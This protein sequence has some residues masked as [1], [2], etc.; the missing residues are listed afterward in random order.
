M[1]SI[2]SLELIEAIK[3]F[4]FVSVTHTN[5]KPT[6][7]FRVKDKNDF[8]LVTFSDNDQMRFVTPEFLA[9]WNRV[10]AASGVPVVTLTDFT[11]YCTIE[12]DGF[13][14]NPFDPNIK[15]DLV[16][17]LASAMDFQEAANYLIR[18][19]P[20]LD[21]SIEGA[22]RLFKLIDYTEPGGDLKIIT[23]NP[24]EAEYLHCNRDENHDAV[25]R[26]LG[27]AEIQ[28]ATR[29]GCNLPLTFQGSMYDDREFLNVV[30]AK[31]SVPVKGE[32]M[33]R[34]ATHVDI[35]NAIDHFIEEY[36]SCMDS[37]FA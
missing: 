20:S 26:F 32:I 23:Q 13:M 35:N 30:C 36:Q 21:N 31:V 10:N 9:T 22:L 11:F 25:F 17:K 8:H 2:L 15:Q 6:R 33:K 5:P 7:V 24:D 14:Y 16:Y 28:D 34:L 12:M 18:E 37:N 1:A 4:Y 29:Q 3:R 19:F 27:R